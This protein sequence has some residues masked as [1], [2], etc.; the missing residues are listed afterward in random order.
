MEILIPKTPITPKFTGVYK[1]TID[2][3]WFYIGCSINLR[4]RFWAWKYKFMSG[5]GNQKYIRDLIRDD[6]VIKFEILKVSES[7]DYAYFTESLEIFYNKDNPFLLNVFK[8]PNEIE[9]SLMDYRVKVGQFDKVGNL[10]R[11]YESMNDAEKTMGRRRVREFFKG[12]SLSV[13]GFTFKKIGS[14]GDFIDFKIRDRK[15]NQGF[16][17]PD[18]KIKRGKRIMKFDL[19]GN[20]IKEY[21][22][23]K[24]AADDIGRTRAIIQRVLKGERKHNCGFI[25]KVK[26]V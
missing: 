12:Y 8:R 26:I 15:T 11:I 23:V 3:K 14:N 10:V 19:N 21:L 13:N 24:E 20:F 4:R 22:S 2:N 7:Y 18:S 16:K 9:L 6:S 1:F 25:Y 17:R 5:V